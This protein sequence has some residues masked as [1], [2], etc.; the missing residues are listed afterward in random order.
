ME[1]TLVDIADPKLAEAMVATALRHFGR[2]DALVNDAG[3]DAPRGLAWEIDEAHWRKIIDVDLSGPWWC[4]KAVLPHMLNRRRG[5][6]VTISS[7]S[8]RTGSGLEGLRGAIAEFGTMRG[9]AR[10][11]ERNPPKASISF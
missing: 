5:K 7:V 8:A 1:S 10:G 3:I 2:V 11:A 9:S 4:I 6:I